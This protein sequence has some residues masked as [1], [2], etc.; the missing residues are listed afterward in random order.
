MQLLQSDAVGFRMQRN[1]GRKRNAGRR[2]GE[3]NEIGKPGRGA[4]QCPGRNDKRRSGRKRRR[5]TAVRLG[6]VRLQTDR[7]HGRSGPEQNAD[8][9][10]GK[11]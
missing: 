1:P 6:P 11:T 4:D 7:R 10:F 2:L 3:N 5:Q 9:L 8:L